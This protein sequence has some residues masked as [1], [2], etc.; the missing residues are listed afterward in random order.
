[1]RIDRIEI[2]SFGKFK[3]KNIDFNEGLNIIYGDNESGKSTIIS[4]IYAILYGFGENRTKSLSLREKYTPWDGGVCEGKILI[5]TDDEKHIS[6]YRKA[7]S[8]KK[9][10]SLHIHDTDTGEELSISPEEI[11]G[12]NAD[13]F[14]KTLCVRQLGVSLNGTNDEISQ[15]LSNIASVGDES[16]SFEKAQKILDSIRREI[17][18][19]R[20]SGGLY[21][22]IT[23][24]L[25]QAEKVQS[26]QKEAQR[27]LTSLLSLLA[28]EEKRKDTVN[29][30]LDSLSNID[31]S[32]SVAHLSGRLEKINKNT[33]KPT[34]FIL[35]AVL[36]IA[37]ITMLFANF[38]YSLIF[39]VLFLVSL[40]AV[41]IKSRF[42]AN[43]NAE[44][45]I[46]EKDI[47]LSKKEENE[48]KIASLRETI[49]LSEERI[50][51]MKVR[52][53]ALKISTQK[54]TVDTKS[55]LEEKA[56]LEKRLRTI[57]LTSKALSSAYENMQKNF[58][59]EL[60]KKASYYFGKIVGGKYSRIFC[61]KDFSIS[62][63]STI[64]RESGF[65]SGGTVDQL[66]LSL[67]LSLTDMLFGEKS[68][69]VI[70]DQPF[71]QYDS[72]RKENALKLFRDIENRRQII[73][74][75]AD[76]SLSSRNI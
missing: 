23:K 42:S 15:K 17:Q 8:V 16:V 61:D 47:L 60:N 57:S 9:Y 56:R 14:L 11:V 70:L 62:I 10:D 67:R 12:V 76:K 43:N 26:E 68:T 13:T 44:S 53:E 51:S 40:G 38:F 54:S 50:I 1:M 63:E 22:E 55:L 21:S 73:L 18:P 35:S 2:I 6:I 20:G 64:P 75:T 37:F 46:K 65:F 59:P 19:Q 27:E 33:L 66:Y 30:E 45:L 48:K 52:E 74:F 29:K 3:N 24:K 31:Y 49:R 4:F 5:T 34:D 28:E 69:P 58:T 36:F 72:V 71:L 41:L 39:F 7:G 25:S 32:S